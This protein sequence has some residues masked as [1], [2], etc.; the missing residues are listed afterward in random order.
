MP[1]SC[2]FI[3]IALQCNLKSRMVIPLDVLL[4]YRIVS[5]SLVFCLFVGWLLVDAF[6]HM[7][8]IFDG[9][10]LRGGCKGVPGKGD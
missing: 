8:L 2:G 3:T 1:I 6:F 7:K 10:R 5:L 4:S 9:G